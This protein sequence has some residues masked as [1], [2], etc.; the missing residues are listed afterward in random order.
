MATNFD[1]IRLTAVY[2]VCRT[3]LVSRVLNVWEQSKQSALTN[4]NM[5]GS[6]RSLRDKNGDIDRE[7]DWQLNARECKV[8]GESIVM[9]KW[10]NARA[11]KVMVTSCRKA[12]ISRIFEMLLTLMVLRFKVSFI[13]DLSMKHIDNYEIDEHKL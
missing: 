13:K 8:N 3:T 9:A 12:E 4:Y 6:S 1:L 2:T 7:R 10:I 5:V 11:S